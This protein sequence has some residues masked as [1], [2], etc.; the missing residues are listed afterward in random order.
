MLGKTCRI[1]YNF[2]AN[3]FLPNCTHSIC[4]KCWYT[5]RK[6]DG[7]NAKCPFCRTKQDNTFVETMTFLFYN[8]KTLHPIYQ[9][10][11]MYGIIKLLD[12]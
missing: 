12:G 5:I 7:S 1:C 10:I 4:K 8:F 9:A 11:I 6:N 2:K 3:Y